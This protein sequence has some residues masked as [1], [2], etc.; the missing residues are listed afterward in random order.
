[1]VA[2][3]VGV[4]DEYAV[5]PRAQELAELALSLIENGIDDLHIALHII[6]ITEAGEHHRLGR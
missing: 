5:V 2:A 6:S 3:M 1:L 4:P